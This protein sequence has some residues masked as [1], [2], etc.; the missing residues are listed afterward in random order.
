MKK[1]IAVLLIIAVIS[2]MGLLA[3]CAKQA[4]DTN[5]PA[6]TTAQKADHKNEVY[7]WACQY[8]SLPLF[9]NNDYIGLDLAA[10]ELGVT[11][12]KV[13]PQKVDLPAFISAIE[14]EIGKKP[15]GMLVVGWDPSEQVA[16]DKAIDAGIPV[17][18]D[19]ADVPASKRLAFVGTDWYQVGVEEAKAVAPYI[20]DKTGKAAVIGLPAADNSKLA[21]A[22]Y[23]DT[24]KTLAPKVQVIQQ[25]Y[26][27]QVNISKVAETSANLIS[28]MPDLVALAGITSE[29]GPGITTAIK[30]ANKIGQVFGTCVDAEPEHLQ[31]VK[32]GALVAA[33]GQKRQF[34]TYYGIK[35]LYDVNHSP[36]KF[37][38]D[39]KKAGISNIPMNIS[40]GFIV[41][42]KD[43]VDMLIEAQNAKQK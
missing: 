1:K 39:D 23:T 28:S 7:A 38:K 15:A 18:T 24:L 2:T 12:E 32:S 8:S 4:T 19:D 25:I 9:V 36:I 10:Q 27:C 16:I 13:G 35:L 33:V 14:Q 17:I 37:T 30:E 5:T 31:G 34:F 29:G 42:T 21:L 6:A 11:I 22:G 26:D 20:K 3:G 40:T 43:N 41:A